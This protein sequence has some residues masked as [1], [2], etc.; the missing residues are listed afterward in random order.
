MPAG[1]FPPSSIISDQPRSSRPACGKCGLYRNCSSPKMPVTGEG[2]RGVLIC[3][4]APG[5]E[6]DEQGVQLVGPVGQYFRRELDRLGVSLDRDCW[7]TNSI[8]CR[9][10]GNRNP[11][12]NE[13]DHCRPSLLN[14]IDELQPKVIILLGKPA[15]RSLIGWLW[16]DD[17]GSIGRWVG[18][19]I[20][21]QKL[22][23]WICPTWHPSYL[24]R[25][26]SSDENKYRVLQIWFRRHLE[27]AFRLSRQPW[28]KPSRWSDD[29]K[30]E[31]DPD[32]AARCIDR[33]T[34]YAESHPQTLVAVDYETDRLKP[35]APDARIVSCAVAWGDSNGL[36][37]N[38]SYPMVG[39]ARDATGRFM[40]SSVRKIVAN[41]GFEIRWTLA[42]FGH[43]VRNVVW[44]TM[45][46]AHLLD[47]RPGITGVKF[48]AYAMLGQSPWDKSIRPYLEAD[49]SNAPNRIHELRIED[50]LRYGGMDSIIEFRLALRQAKMMGVSL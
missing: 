25:E 39:V 3:A 22:N 33:I 43:G 7:K 15:V 24:L 9:P 37:G 5:A 16:R 40:R 46:D 19:R 30:I 31:M 50:L 20:P 2:R 26:Q 34:K 8:I 32:V 47:N 45:H 10:P 42:E 1:F 27:A 23:T 11:T 17:P 36:V 48:L 38:L 18:W 29:V 6:E 49:T 28:K 14:A 12:N 41:K 13:I 35:D 21:D 44:D 4:E